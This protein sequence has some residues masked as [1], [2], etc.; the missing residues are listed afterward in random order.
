[1]NGILTGLSRIGRKGENNGKSRPEIITFVN[2][3]YHT[4]MLTLIWGGLPPP[5][6]CWF[7][8]NNS[9]TV[10]AVTMAFCSIQ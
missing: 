8:I 9:E 2:C 7:S 4:N 10:K 5:P 3:G 1:M 6:S